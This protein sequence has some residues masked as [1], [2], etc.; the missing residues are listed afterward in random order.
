MRRSRRPLCGA[1][2]PGLA[3]ARPTTSIDGPQLRARHDLRRE[4]L[5]LLS[6]VRARDSLLPVVVMT[7]WSSV[8][9]AVEAMQHGPLLDVCKRL[10]QRQSRGRWCSNEDRGRFSAAHHDRGHAVPGDVADAAVQRALLPDQL[11]G[12]G[13]AAELAARWEPASTLGGD[14]YDVV[15]LPGIGSR[16]VDRRRVR[17]G[18]ARGAADDALAGVGAGVRDAAGRCPRPSSRP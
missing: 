15:A 3:P 2:W 17:Q 16:A 5:E 13:V 9:I 11:A 4:G 10:E 1:S 7:G 8:E 14:C 18:S 6:Q 12:G